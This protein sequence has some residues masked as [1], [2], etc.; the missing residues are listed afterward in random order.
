MP[1]I[2]VQCLDRS[3]SR[4]VG[5]SRSPE[6]KLTSDLDNWEHI[7]TDITVPEG[8]SM[9]RVRVGIPAEGNGGGT[10]IIDDVAIAEAR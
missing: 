8:T 10:A 6:R 7:A 4:Y 3:G 1:M 9:L 5:F 2:V